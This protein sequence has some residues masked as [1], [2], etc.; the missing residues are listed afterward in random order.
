[1]AQDKRTGSTEQV[2]T[3]ASYRCKV[4]WQLMTTIKTTVNKANPMYNS[5]LPDQPSATWTWYSE[6]QSSIK[7]EHT[8]T[9]KLHN[10]YKQLR[11]DNHE[12]NG[13]CA[14]SC[15]TAQELLPCQFQT[16]EQSSTTQH[17]FLISR[18]PVQAHSHHPNAQYPNTTTPLQ[19]NKK[20]PEH[21]ELSLNISVT[22]PHPSKI[23]P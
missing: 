18:K 16:T 7:V 14:C 5:P 23:K 12:Q 21:N 2:Q 17:L 6:V 8:L 11:L 19:M 13:L 3:E 4:S 9:L 1:M 10:Y 15:C 22:N 20:Q